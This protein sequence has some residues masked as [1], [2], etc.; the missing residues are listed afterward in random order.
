MRECAFRA[1]TA[2]ATAA[3]LSA[4]A[5]SS[6]QRAP[7]YPTAQQRVPPRS[8]PAPAASA[9][10]F[11]ATSGSIELLIIRSSELALQRSA[12]ARIRDFAEIMIR[13]HKGTSAQLS[14]AGRRLNLL[15][16]ASLQPREQA[17]LDSLS[18]APD[19]DAT[20]VRLQR[21]AHQNLLALDQA[22]AAQGRSPTVRPV[23][24]AAIPIEQ[25]HLRLLAYL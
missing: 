24:Q 25:R 3:L 10:T 21:T 13:D 15:P 5:A 8:A 23:A 20:F 14:F 18:A 1:I 22:Y 16:S 6:E 7:T 9:A 17:A 2:T 4:C 12:A 19:F 11:V